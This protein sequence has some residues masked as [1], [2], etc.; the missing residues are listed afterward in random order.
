MKNLID[1]IVQKTAQGWLGKW[2]RLS[3]MVHAIFWLSA[4]SAVIFL[5]VFR[6]VENSNER[7]RLD[8]ELS[9]QQQEWKKQEKILQTLR[10]KSD[11]RQLSPELANSVLPINQH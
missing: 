10:Q 7:H 3:Q 11:S 8:A 6:Y 5:P 1:E 4:L 9:L 2:L